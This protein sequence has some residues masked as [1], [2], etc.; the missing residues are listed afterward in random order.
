MYTT[1]IRTGQE[2]YEVRM[3]LS[4]GNVTDFAAQPRTRP[5]PIAFRS[6]RSIGREYLIR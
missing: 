2:E 1:S 4:G 6:V 3:M 5:V